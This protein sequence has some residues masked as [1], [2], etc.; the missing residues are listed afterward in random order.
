MRENKDEITIRTT[1]FALTTLTTIGLG[2]Y[3]PKNNAERICMCF[4]MICGVATFTIIETNVDTAI[5]KILN[6]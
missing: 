2:D 6:I 3:H 1:Y 4:M 5:R